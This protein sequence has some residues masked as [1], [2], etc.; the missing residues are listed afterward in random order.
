[1][2]KIKRKAK[3]LQSCSKK[4]KLNRD[5]S[6]AKGDEEDLGEKELNSVQNFS[7]L[8]VDEVKNGDDEVNLCG[9]PLSLT[10]KDAGAGA[11]VTFVLEKASLTLANIGKRYQILNSN[12]HAG[13]LRK[14]K[15]DPY[16]YRPDIVHEA[17]NDIMNSRLSKG[18]RLKAVYIRTEDG[19]LIKVE[20]YAKIPSDLESFCSMMAELLQTLS[21]KAKGN[22]KKLLRVV[23]NPVTKYLPPS[24]PKIGLSFS[25]EKAVE[26]REHVS[27]INRDEDVVFVVGVMAHGKIE[28]DYIEDLVSVSPF[29]LS[30]AMCLRI[31]LIAMERKWSIL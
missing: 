16:K 3:S 4:K 18:G 29:H 10:C 12:E 14:K 23:A 11:G 5:G 22:R 28:C 15:M 24:S 26:L 17:L 25:S 21:I 8:N 19:V 6:V 20:P 30:A 13:Y 7:H 9:I 31:I 1:M 2:G 27:G